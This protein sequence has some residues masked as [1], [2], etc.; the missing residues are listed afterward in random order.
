MLNF[1]TPIFY[2]SH[3]ILFLTI[4]DGILAIIVFSFMNS[5]VTTLLAPTIVLFGIF[6]SF[7][8]NT[9]LYNQT[10]FPIIMFFLV[11][12]CIYYYLNHI[13]YENLHTLFVNLF[14]TYNYFLFL[15]FYYL[16]YKNL[17]Y[18]FL[19]DKNLCQF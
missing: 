5:F 19:F 1:N 8:I 6:A 18:I 13:F 7:K 4:L 11:Y 3:L 9:S 10:L 15:L 12:L 14:Q 16:N 17:L 2:F